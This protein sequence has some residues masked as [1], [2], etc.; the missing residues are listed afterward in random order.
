MRCI[1]VIRN[2]VN[3]KVY[4]GQTKNFVIRKA[5]HLYS[6][7]RGLSRPLYSAI[8]KYGE[9]NFIFEVL[10]ECDDVTINEREQHWV[11]HFDSFNPEKGYNLTSG[12]QRYFS[13]SAV[14]REKMMG[15][16]VSD[17]T[18]RKI[19]KANKNPSSE[20]RRKMSNSKKGKRPNNF[21]KSLSAETRNLLR[22]AS[23]R[24]WKKRKQ[25]KSL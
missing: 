6:S 19:G 24:S 2:L 13:H 16:P 7:R 21:G 8:R 9:E 17:E 11:T 1:Y 10:E 5:Q 12:G 18:R 25:E 15:H 3:N 23:L 14:V 20:T 4:V 22:E